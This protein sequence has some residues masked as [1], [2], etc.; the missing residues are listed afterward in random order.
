MR[1]SNAGWGGPDNPLIVSTW[2]RCLGPRSGLGRAPSTWVK[3]FK[4]WHISA[5][6]SNFTWKGLRLIVHLQSLWV[7]GTGPHCKLL[8]TQTVRNGHLL[9]CETD[10]AKG[11]SKRPNFRPSYSPW[12]CQIS[13]LWSRGCTQVSHRCPYFGKCLGRSEHVFPRCGLTGAAG[14]SFRTIQLVLLIWA[15]GTLKAFLLTRL[16]CQQWWVVSLA[17]YCCVQSPAS[18][19][20][21]KLG[22]HT[23]WAGSF[24]RG[25]E[26]IFYLFIASFPPESSVWQLVC[27]H[28]S[29]VEAFG[30]HLFQLGC[31]VGIW[32]LDG[33]AGRAQLWKPSSW[34]RT[35]HLKV[36][37]EGQRLVMSKKE[38]W[39]C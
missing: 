21:A 33:F 36:L 37:E 27:C 13:S 5:S 16:Q 18:C 31:W 2:T 22:L 12:L 19:F 20:L 3:A 9:A 25:V 30:A 38:L 10:A 6:R 23:H 35:G 39:K 29:P 15:E 11:V 34:F 24:H 28:E 7:C 32:S 17:C 8:P 14:R 4:W 26:V 1:S